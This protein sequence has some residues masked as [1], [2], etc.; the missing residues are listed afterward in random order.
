MDE[1][2]DEDKIGGLYDEEIL[3]PTV[4][5]DKKLLEEACNDFIEDTKQRF[6]GLAKE[7][8]TEKDRI[9]IPNTK[10]S[11]L[12][13]EEDLKDGDEPEEVKRKVREKRILN[14]ENFEEEAQEKI[15]DYDEDSSE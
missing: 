11:E 15:D 2:Y 7:F 8:G 3:P 12:V 14:A 1:E 13:H 10:C 9:L 4:K 6:Q 5:N